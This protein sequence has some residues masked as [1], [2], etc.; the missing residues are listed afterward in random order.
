M[1][2]LMFACHE[3]V[4]VEGH[5]IGLQLRFPDLRVGRS[6]CSFENCEGN[7]QQAGG[8]TGGEPKT[9]GQEYWHS[10]SKKRA[11]RA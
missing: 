5:E 8:R 2:S 11:P 9:F 7:L 10:A 3:N 6:G 1:D 4:A